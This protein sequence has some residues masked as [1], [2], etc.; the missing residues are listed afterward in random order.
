M[1]PE[2][3]KLVLVLAAST[4]VSKTREETVEAVEIAGVGK[5]GEKSEREYLENLA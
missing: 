3:K 4:P 5:D 1:F 2:A